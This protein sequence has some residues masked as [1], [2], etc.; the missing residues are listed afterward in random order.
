LLNNDHIEKFLFFLCNSLSLIKNICRQVLE[1][2]KEILCVLV[3]GL[4]IFL[5]V[6]ITKNTQITT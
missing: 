3:K 1:A 4:F 2:I 5:S 6:T